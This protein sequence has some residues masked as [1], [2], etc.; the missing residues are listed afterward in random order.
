MHAPIPV[1][2]LT[3]ARVSQQQPLQVPAWAQ[4]DVRIESLGALNQ[5][6]QNTHKS[7]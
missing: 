1:D 6:V 2:A 3:Q 5:Q 7:R 4:R